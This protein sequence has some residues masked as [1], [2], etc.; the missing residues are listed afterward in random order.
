MVSVMLARFRTGNEFPGDWYGWITNQAG[1]SY[2]VGFPFAV[3]GTLLGL[4][5]IS[6]SVATYILY[7]LVW[8]LGLKTRVNMRD[9]L[10][11]PAHVTTDAGLFSALCAGDLVIGVLIFLTQLAF[12]LNGVRRRLNGNI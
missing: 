6:I 11:D 12:L 3:V 9:S 8:E 10:C 4:H 1:H 2:F 7:F 5:W